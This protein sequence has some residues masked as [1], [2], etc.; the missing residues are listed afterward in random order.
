[1][2]TFIGHVIRSRKDKTATVLVKTQRQHPLYK[3][4]IKKTKKFLVHDTLG[5]KKGQ[6]VIIA[7]TRPI[8]KRKRFKAV[9]ILEQK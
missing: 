9:K 1:M 3:K 6:K 2:K 4:T 7:E 8:S 5:L